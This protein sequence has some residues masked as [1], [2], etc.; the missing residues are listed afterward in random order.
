M[1]IQNNNNYVRGINDCFISDLQSGVL[2]NFL[3][4]CNSKVFSLEIRKDYV[5]IYYK[6]GNAIKITQLT[7]GYIFYFDLKYCLNLDKVNIVNFTILS[8]L[9]NQSINDY[10][11]NIDRIKYE[12]D[13]W[14][15]KHPNPE[16]DFQHKL[17]KNNHSNFQ[18]IDIEYAIRD[19]ERR[20]LNRLEESENQKTLNSSGLTTK[21]KE[22][23]RLD[24]LA[25]Y[26]ENGI[27]KLV[28]VENKFGDNLG[29]GS[30]VKQHLDDINHI[31]N[32]V[33]LRTQLISSVN[34]VM[35]NKMDLGLVNKYVP[36]NGSSTIE[37]LF[38]LANY[39][40]NISNLQSITNTVHTS[41]V[42]KAIIIPAGTPHTNY[43]IDYSKAIVI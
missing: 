3:T 29:G 1:S 25:I 27:Y 19:L 43:K 20:E 2:N 26:F 41:F 38:I 15:N 35:K 33:T 42:K 7:N 13:T 4:L 22:L 32:D 34:S 9:N 12:M 8:N 40:K 18:I 6:G 30:S 14:F 16:R 36:F 5:N 21:L 24:M 31:L 11:N 37:V 39:G 28:I 23:F 17:T 10:W